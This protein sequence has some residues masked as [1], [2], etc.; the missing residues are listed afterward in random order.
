[1]K[2][3]KQITKADMYIAVCIICLALKSP[4]HA[5]YALGFAFVSIVST[6]FS[7]GEE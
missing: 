4:R 2:F 1:M 6:M 7:R 3:T 5:W